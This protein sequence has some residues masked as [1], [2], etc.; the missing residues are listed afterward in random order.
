MTSSRIPALDAIACKVAP[1]PIILSTWGDLGNARERMRRVAHPAM[2]GGLRLL[3]EGVDAGQEVVRKQ[4][5]EPEGDVEIGVLGLGLFET[6]DDQDREIGVALAQL[7]D[8][9]GA[10]H[11]GHQV[12]GDDQAD[13]FGDLPGVELLKG[14]LGAQGGDN[15]VTGSLEDGLSGRGLYGIIVNEQNRWRHLGSQL[16]WP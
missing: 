9:G 5:F 3:D 13:V 11:A 1:V 10:I 2:E 15:G 7:R 12:V 4:G 14:E 16:R 6:A 8:E